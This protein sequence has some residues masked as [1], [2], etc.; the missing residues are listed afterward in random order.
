MRASKLPQGRKDSLCKKNKY[1]A[2]IVRQYIMNDPVPSSQYS[3]AG[4]TTPWKIQTYN[5][6]IVKFL[7]I[8]L[9]PPNP[10]LPDTH[11]YMHLTLHIF[12]MKKYY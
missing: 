9:E 3:R 12:L 4:E 7:K 6:P 11:I 2:A 10:H 1:L 8:G 5:T